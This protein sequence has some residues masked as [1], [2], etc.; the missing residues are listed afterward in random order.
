[1]KYSGTRFYGN[2]KQADYTAP[3]FNFRLSVDLE[4]R[5]RLFFEERELFNTEKT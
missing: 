2:I 3:R 5:Q 4:T 1:M